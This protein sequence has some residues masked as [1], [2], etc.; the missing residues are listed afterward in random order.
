LWQFGIFPLFGYTKKLKSGNPDRDNFRVPDSTSALLL[1]S[2][3]GGVVKKKPVTILR[4]GLSENSA[5]MVEKLSRLDS[6]SDSGEEDKEEEE[7]PASG[8]DTKGS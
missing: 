8:D 2:G 6:V 5:R 3:G 7:N 4:K 1:L